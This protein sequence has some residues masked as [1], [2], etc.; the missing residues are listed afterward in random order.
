MSENSKPTALILYEASRGQAISVDDYERLVKVGLVGIGM[1]TDINQ[2]N[3]R[4]IR[5]TI[6]E[7]GDQ[8][9]QKALAN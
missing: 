6:T 3:A 9:I 8:I 5:T 4:Q 7:K 2:I 1:Y